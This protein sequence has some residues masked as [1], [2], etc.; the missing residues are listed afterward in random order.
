[1]TTARLRL[2]SL[3]GDMVFV[4][5]FVFVLVFVSGFINRSEGVSAT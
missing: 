4:F 3:Q 2:H 5:V 1:M